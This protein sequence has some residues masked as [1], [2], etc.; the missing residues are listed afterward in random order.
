LKT[1]E[2]VSSLDTSSYPVNVPVIPF[3]YVDK[4]ANVT[5]TSIASVNGLNPFETISIM[6]VEL[7]PKTRV[8]PNV[9]T[10]RKPVSKY[11]S[12]VNSIIQKTLEKSIFVT[13]VID[14]VN[15]PLKL[16]FLTPQM[17]Q[18]SY[19]LMSK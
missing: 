8:E 17:I 7:C 12:R 5:E 10:S 16:I 15:E 9:E 3:Y 18:L 6:H 1:A 11:I 4:Q 19:H 2:K 14:D 13:V